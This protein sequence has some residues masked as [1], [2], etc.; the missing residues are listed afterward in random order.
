MVLFINREKPRKREK[1][2]FTNSYNNNNKTSRVLKHD[3]KIVLE[4]L[5]AKEEQ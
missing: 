2:H 5:N 4:D 1:K 3:V